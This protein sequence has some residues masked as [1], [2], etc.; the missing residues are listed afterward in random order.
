MSFD[1]DQ[2]YCQEGALTST[3]APRCDLSSNCSSYYLSACDL[4][5]WQ[6]Q[7]T[8]ICVGEKLATSVIQEEKKRLLACSLDSER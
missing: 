2:W 4:Y 1:A 6:T 8:S 7:V 3:D 5:Y